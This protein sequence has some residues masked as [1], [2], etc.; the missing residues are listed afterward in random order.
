MAACGT[1]Q[2]A[3]GVEAGI[4]RA[5]HAVHLQWAQHSHEEDWGFLLIDTRNEFNEENRTAMLWA[6]RHEWLGGAQFTFNCYRH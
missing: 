1:E 2:L 6:V 3:G 4:E 5:I